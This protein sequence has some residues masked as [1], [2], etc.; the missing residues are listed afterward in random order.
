MLSAPLDRPTLRATSASEGGLSASAASNSAQARATGLLRPG[1]APLP[2]TQSRGL[3]RLHARK[4]AASA[5]SGEAWK[6]TFSRSGARAAQ[7][8][9]QKTPVVLTENQNRPL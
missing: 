8:G 7:D 6:A 5:A 1:S 9:R 2:R 4:P 3:Q